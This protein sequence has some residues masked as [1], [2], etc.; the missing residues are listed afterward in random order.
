M[1]A[2]R[3]PMIDQRRR[4]AEIT[5]WVIDV[6]SGIVIRQYMDNS[7]CEIQQTSSKWCWMASL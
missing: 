3:L 6:R 2:L 7:C 1:H 5:V 4:K